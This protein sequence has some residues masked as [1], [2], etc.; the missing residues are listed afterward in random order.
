MDDEML[1]AGD[2][3]EQELHANLDTGQ[4]WAWMKE[5]QHVRMFKRIEKGLEGVLGKGRYEWVD[6][7]VFDEVFDQ[8]TLMA[9]FK[10]MKQGHIDTLEFPI[11]RGKEAHVFL[12]TTS[13][14]PAAVKIFH[15]SN[16]VF[17][18]LLK[19][20]EGDPRFSGLRRRHRHLVTL[21]VRKEHRN[22]TRLS[23]HGLRVPKPLAVFQ[24]VLVL[25]YLGDEI[26]A[27]PRLRDVHIDDPQLVYR[28]M[29]DFLAIAWQSA[30]LVHADF[31]EYNILWHA[32]QAWVIDVGQA[33]TDQHPLASEFLVRDVTR[34]VHWA[35]KQ[36]LDVDLADAM[37]H[38]LDADVSQEE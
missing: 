34:L 31:S 33:V 5:K 18:G 29:L 37:A 1:R 17:K 25:E 30:R 38:V 24:N 12:A 36:G 26:S 23:K 20:I 28:E 15:T 2:E 11:A 22:L 7:R 4:D 14:G 10:L 32:D 27:A 6:R 3:E 35:N 13:H 8:S 19:Y 21:W 9:L 16:A